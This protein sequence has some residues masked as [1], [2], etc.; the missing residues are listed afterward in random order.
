LDLANHPDDR[1]AYDRIKQEASGKRNRR[2]EIQDNV[3]RYKGQVEGDSTRAIAR[4]EGMLGWFKGRERFGDTT[5]SAGEIHSK[6]KDAFA[7]APK[8]SYTRDLALMAEKA[9]E[10]QR[11]GYDSTRDNA[12]VMLGPA[13]QLHANIVGYDDLDMFEDE[14]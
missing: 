3:A 10:K 9:S 13:S 7:K 14:Y 6:A 5:A 12:A 2:K 1:V 11:F 8:S 4:S